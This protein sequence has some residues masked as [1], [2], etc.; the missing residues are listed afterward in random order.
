MGIK[1]KN[2]I[3][4]A[5]L[6]VDNFGGYYTVEGNSVFYTS[7]AKKKYT[8]RY[9]DSDTINI[10]PVITY[11]VD[12]MIAVAKG[13]IGMIKY[14]TYKNIPKTLNRKEMV[15]FEEFIVY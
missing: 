4:V 6:L 7:K 10:R 2:N 9:T 3:E 5:K 11:P 15:H 13:L 14:D 1:A 12:G 8:C